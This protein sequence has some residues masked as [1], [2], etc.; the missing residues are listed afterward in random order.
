MTTSIFKTDAEI[1]QDTLAELERDW[2]FKPAEIGVEVDQGVVTLTGT[3]SSYTKLLAAGDIASEIGGVR[4]VANELTVHTPGIGTPTDTDL[5]GAVRNALKWDPEVPDEHIDV[6]VRGGTVTLKGNVDYWYQR[7]AACD[8]AMRIAGVSALNDHITVTPP[9][10]SDG[11]IRDEIRKAIRRR[12]PLAA[13][14]VDVQVQDGTVTLTGKVQFYSDR[15]Q[16]EKAAWMT[17]GVR[18]VVNTLE[19]TW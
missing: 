10:Q 16:A 12:A 18:N 2:R 6:L 17:E 8:S 4:G 14:H 3:V 1:R 15:L 19:T 13:D 7:K 11:E 5:A 9:Q